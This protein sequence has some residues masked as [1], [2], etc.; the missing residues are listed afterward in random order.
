MLASMECS[1][2]GVLSPV[3]ESSASCLRVRNKPFCSSTRTTAQVIKGCLYRRR[4][5][6][7]AKSIDNLLW[8]Y[9]QLTFKAEMDLH[10]A[11][12]IL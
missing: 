12:A 11:V 6:V 8:V 5:E 1:S 3:L 10:W 9:K 7:K 4:L 2:F